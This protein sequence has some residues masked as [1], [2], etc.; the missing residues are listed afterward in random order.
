MLNTVELEFLISRDI[1][2]GWR[3]VHS[4]RTGEGEQRAFVYNEKAK[5]YLCCVVTGLDSGNPRL[6]AMPS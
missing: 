6:F 1:G 4:Y 5:E 3:L 2:P